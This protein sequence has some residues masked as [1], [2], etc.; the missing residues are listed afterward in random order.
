MPTLRIH[1]CWR[2]LALVALAA[3][4]VP[5]AAGAAFQATPVATPAEETMIVETAEGPVRGEVLAGY[6]RFRGIPYAAPPVADL[7]WRAPQPVAAWTGVLDVTE[8]GSPCPQNGD[9]L[10][11]GDAGAE[12]CLY[13][14][15]TAPRGATPHAPKPVLIWQHGGGFVGAAGSFFDAQRLATQGDLVV[16]TINYRLGILGYFGYPGLAGSGNFG[17]Q[18]QRA[19][20]EWVQLNIAAFGGDPD[21]VTLAGNRRGR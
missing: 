20:M 4:I 10:Y 12:D 11:G 5:L 2:L 8:P 3:M 7:R 15:V 16:V 13:L 14:E 1:R 19:A 21:N 18:D 6:R 9:P 17:L